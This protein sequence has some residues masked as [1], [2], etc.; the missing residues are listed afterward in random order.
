[1]QL[2]SLI[3]LLK[4]APAK[5][6]SSIIYPDSKN[7]HSST[8]QTQKQANTLVLLGKIKRGTGW[9]AVNEYEGNYGEHDRLL[10]ELIAR[11]ARLKLPLSVYREHS[12]PIGIRSDLVVLIGKGNKAICGVIEAKNQNETQPT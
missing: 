10:T 7:P 4:V 9:Y 8:V 12:F 1:M 11:L 5:T 3:Q 2:Y 6:I